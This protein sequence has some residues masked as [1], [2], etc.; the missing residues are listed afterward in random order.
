MITPT[1]MRRQR[2]ILSKGYTSHGKGLLRYANSK[3]YDKTLGDD[4][5]QSTFLKTWTYIVKGGKVDMMEAFLFHI[6]KALIIDE[7]RK[8]KTTSLDVLIEKGFEPSFDDTKRTIDIHDGKQA[9]RLIAGLPVQYQKIMRMRYVQDLSL[10]EIS[11][12]TG[13]STNAVAVLSHRGLKKLKTLY[14]IASQGV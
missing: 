4:L 3:I 11:L 5:V 7:Y 8:R 14:K 9:I 1:Q 12:I 10:K 13:K 2:I 6:L